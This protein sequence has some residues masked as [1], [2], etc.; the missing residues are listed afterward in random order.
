MLSLTIYGITIVF[1]L[2]VAVVIHGLGA[3]VARFSL[4]RNDAPVDLE[5]PSADARREAEAVAVAVAVAAASRSGRL[6]AK[7]PT[8][9]H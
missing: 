8:S 7:S 5:M 2:L 1:A 6:A 4:E 9:T 3:V